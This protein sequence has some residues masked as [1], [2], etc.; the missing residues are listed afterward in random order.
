MRLLWVVHFWL[1]C[2]G[3]SQVPTRDSTLPG[4]N[5]SELKMRNFMYTI[6]CKLY[7]I[8]S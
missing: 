8:E 1:L 3:Y 6:F 2:I 7:G 4:Q 5:F